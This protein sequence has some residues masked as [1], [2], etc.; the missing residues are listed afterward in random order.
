MNSD[1]S[2]LATTLKPL[3]GNY[4]TGR[5]NTAGKQNSD[6]CEVIFSLHFLFEKNDKIH[7]INVIE[8]LQKIAI[9]ECYT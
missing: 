5:T 1:Q 7:K 9:S 2:F 4:Y 3:K 6:F 8:W